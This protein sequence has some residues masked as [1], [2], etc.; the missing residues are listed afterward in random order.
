[1]SGQEQALRGWS[2]QRELWADANW[3][4]WVLA[5]FLTR[6]CGTMM[7]FALL[8]E[9]E[10]AL[11]SFSAGAWMTSAYSVGTALAA[12]FRGR[13]M[14]RRRLPDAMRP[15]LRMLAV[16]SAAVALACA[17]RAPLPVLL[18]LSLLLGVI[19]AGVVGAYRALLPSFLPPKRLAPAFSI[20]AVLI[21]VTWIGGPLLVGAL[22][23]A[24]PSLT[25]GAIGV[26]AML[27]TLA[28]RRLPVREPPPAPA[29]PSPRLALEPFLR[30]VPLFTYVGSVAVGLSWGAVDTALPPRLVQL[31]SRA[32]LWGG[33]VALL[34]VTSALGG[35]I[36]AGTARAG[37]TRQSLW[38]ALLFAAL[39]G[40][41]LLPMS[42]SERLMSMGVWLAAAGFFLAPLSG[43][44]SYLLQQALPAA[45][46]AEGF[47][48]YSASWSIGIGAGSA[49]TA[50]LLEHASARAAII[51]AG[52]VPLAMA[53]AAVPLVRPLLRSSAEPSSPLTEVAAREPEAGAGAGAP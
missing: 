29:T 27:A 52:G 11:G 23:L 37:S 43:L 17:V 19:P 21:E 12:P 53:L 3:H 30:G 15:P 7:P 39:W 50:V 26:S 32:E 20:D 24:H 25:L 35:L 36:Y 13:S 44:L 4:R 18:A 33:L 6:M 14:D 9:G 8:L 10:A 47:A 38:R 22:A 2:A 49:L 51:L 28:N 41:L 45:R 46:H 34:S 40:G 5:A 1:V 16:L 42:L 48:L 31:G